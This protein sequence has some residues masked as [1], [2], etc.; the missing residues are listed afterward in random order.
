MKDIRSLSKEQLLEACLE[1]G[2]KKFRANQLW[3]WL[4]LKS[5]RSFEE[6]TNLSL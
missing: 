2:E 5:A 4:W 3:E 6:M 1:L